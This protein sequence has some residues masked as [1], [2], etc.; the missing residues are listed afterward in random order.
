MNTDLALS[1]DKEWREKE[2][3]KQNLWYDPRH[4]L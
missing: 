2:I 3:A 4:G 1:I